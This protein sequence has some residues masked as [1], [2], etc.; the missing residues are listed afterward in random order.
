M[1][2]SL[3]MTDQPARV[4]IVDD[5][6]HNREL[7]EL[8]LAPCGYILQTAS[9]GED[10]LAIVGQQPPDLIVLD[11]VMPGMNGYEVTATI[12]GNPATRNIPV[13]IITALDDRH[14]RMLGLNAGAEDFLSKPVDRAELCARVQNLVR[15]KAYGDYYR[16][17]SRVLERR[18]RML[19]TTLSSIS[20]FAYVFDREGRFV[21]VNQPL[22]DLWGITLEEAAGK[23]LI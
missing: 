22:L 17:K 19:T 1:T 12:K 6:R 16:S 15:L 7:L 2:L 21:Y 20:D 10:A 13:I 9:G 14:A 5:E 18:E 8:M 3:D 4:L 23:N 11:V